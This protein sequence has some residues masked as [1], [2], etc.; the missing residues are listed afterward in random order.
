MCS[1]AHALHIYLH[2]VMS[3][4]LPLRYMERAYRYCIAI[5]VVMPPALFCFSVCREPPATSPALNKTVV[6]TFTAA[7]HQCHF[8][9]Q[10]APLNAVDARTCPRCSQVQPSDVACSSSVE[11]AIAA[12]A[13]R[14][15]TISLLSRACG[16]L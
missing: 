16:D 9:F 6:L 1:S 12:F 7:A 5:S 15:K 11:N 3:Y 13:S 4:A 8:G 14:K 2:C 10:V